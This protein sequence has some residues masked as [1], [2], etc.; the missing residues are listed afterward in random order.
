MLNLRNYQAQFA[1]FNSYMKERY[2]LNKSF[3][4]DLKT[5]GDE[6]V[7]A[8]AAEESA[9]M[10]ALQTRQQFAVQAFSMGSQTEQGLLRLLG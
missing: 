3:A 2:D 8:D 4:T 5:M 9:N 6:L 10:V 7:A 1:T